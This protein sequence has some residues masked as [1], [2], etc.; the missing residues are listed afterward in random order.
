MV[1]SDVVPGDARQE[2]PVMRPSGER[3][4]VGLRGQSGVG[5]N[6]VRRLPVGQ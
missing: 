5:G 1:K 4:Q 2:D 6:G 3:L